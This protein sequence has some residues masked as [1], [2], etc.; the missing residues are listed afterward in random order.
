MA[1]TRVDKAYQHALAIAMDIILD[2]MCSERPATIYTVCVARLLFERVDQL[3][4]A[5]TSSRIGGNREPVCESEFYLL[6]NLA[7]LTIT[8]PVTS[9]A[10]KYDFSLE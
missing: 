6:Q 10:K 1:Q 4:R 8:R 5:G 2:S 3:W 7:A 9:S